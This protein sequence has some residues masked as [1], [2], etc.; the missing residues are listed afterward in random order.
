MIYILIPVYNE[1]ENIGNLYNELQN[2]IPEQKK[3]IVFSDDGSTDDSIVLIKKLF[4]DIPHQ[5]ISDG[6]NR[7]PGGAFNVGLEW[8]LQDSQDS[9]DLV[10]T[11][12]A[13]STSDITLLPKMITIH[14]L[15]FDLVLASVYAQGGGFEGTTFFR[16]FISTIANLIFPFLFAEC[17]RMGISIIVAFCLMAFNSIS[18]IHKNPFSAIITSLLAS[19]FLNNDILYRR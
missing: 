16:K 1:T 4:I 14:K 8:I 3:L 7:G 5:I 9:N 19:I 15:G 2:I 6:I 10:V 17:N 18:S 13:D 12:E 11:L